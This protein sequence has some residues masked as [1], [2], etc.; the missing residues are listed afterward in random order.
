MK[1]K[2]LITHNNANKKKLV[3]GKCT[4]RTEYI[5]GLAKASIFFPFPK[6][7]GGHGKIT[8]PEQHHYFYQIARLMLRVFS[9]SK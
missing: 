1:I 7:L 9:T 3:Q 6:Y 5:K 8:G 4:S 2:P